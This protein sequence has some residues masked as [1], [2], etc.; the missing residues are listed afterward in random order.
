[1]EVDDVS[2]P[3][4]LLAPRDIDA[5]TASVGLEQVAAGWL[6]LGRLLAARRQAACMT[7]HDLA[8]RVHFSRSTVANSETGRRSGSASAQFWL[9]CDEVLNTGGELSSEAQR[10]EELRKSLTMPAV[11]VTAS[12]ATASAAPVEAAAGATAVPVVTVTVH[13]SVAGT[14]RVAVF[15][16]ADASTCA[17]PDDVQVR[18]GS[19]GAGYPWPVQVGVA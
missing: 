18:T 17:V 3:I 9:R 7:Q 16:D 4:R 2:D 10:L 13:G 5:R 6:R 19:P 1:M 8:G 14:L 15:V 12:D 11:V